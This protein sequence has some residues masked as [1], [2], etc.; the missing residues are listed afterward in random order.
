MAKTELSPEAARVA[1]DTCICFNLQRAARSQARRYDEALRPSG[2]TNGQFAAMMML[3]RPVPPTIGTLAD[4]L[5]MDRTTL[6]ALLKSLQRR[7]LVVS[8]AAADD[9]RRRE[10]TLTAEGRRILGIAWP[11]WRDV[12]ART[13]GITGAPSPATFATLL[14]PFV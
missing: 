11:L 13:E 8:S 2:L 6:T 4:D 12:Q 1:R 3:M 9:S 5:S 14:Q 10:L 7:G